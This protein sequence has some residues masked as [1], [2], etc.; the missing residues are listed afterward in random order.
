MAGD[1]EISLCWDP[2][3]DQIELWLTSPEGR[4]VLKVHPDEIELAYD[5]PFAF[6]ERKADPTTSRAARA[7]A[8]NL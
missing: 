7:I 8:R 4:T 1:V 2:G 3:K 5:H 6:W